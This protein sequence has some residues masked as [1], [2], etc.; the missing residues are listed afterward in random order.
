MSTVSRRAFVAGTAGVTAGVLAGLD[1]SAQ[2][3][4]KRGGTLV[5]ASA[6][7]PTLNP[8][9]LSGGGPG[10]PGAQLFA[11]LLEFDDQFR[12]RPYL[13]TSWD[14]SADGLAYTFHLVPTAVFHDGAP[15]TS[16]DVAF[17]LDT[18]RANSPFGPTMFGSVDRVETPDSHTAKFVMKRPDPAFLS[19]LAPILL[20]VL[21]KHVFDK[22]PIRMNPANLAPVGSGPF[23]F[24]EFKQ[25]NYVILER[26][27]NFFRPNRPLLDKIVIRIIHDSETLVLAL[28]SGEIDYVSGEGLHYSDIL[29]LQKNKKFVTT[30]K[31]FEA[32]GPVDY[33]QFNLR[34]PPFNK[35]LV[36]QAIAHAIDKNFI[37]DKLQYGLTKRLD[38]PLN[39][40]NPFASKDLTLYK[41]DLEKAKKLLNEAGYPMKGDARF[42]VTLDA[43]PFYP[44]GLVLVADYLKP[45]LKRIGIDVEQR[46][47]PDFG[48][49]VKW[50]SNYEYDF[51]MNSSWNY[52]DPTIGVSRLFLCNNQRK[53]VMWANNEG[54]CNP[55]VDHL[56]NT[57]AREMHMDVRKEL[58][59]SFQKNVTT[60]LPFIW[61]TTETLYAVFNKS[62]HNVQ[63]TVWG[64]L[65]PLDAAYK[66]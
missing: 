17:S 20:P 37:V 40:E 56:L 19:C 23:K 58:Y 64:P 44:D 62:V 6:G 57:A 49:W 2:A 4:P 46:T 53:G 9:I 12:P 45:Q 8:A 66:T 39:P 26:F 52:P 51:T 38:G 14:M 35:A 10:L 29:R 65:Q 59:R 28:E 5:I 25:G 33:L 61:T 50:I 32:L 55:V 3:E 21:P 15:I 63:N 48:T 34:K 16:E 36:R 31:G 1:R 24:V 60:D 30:R 47:S 13:A 18:V 41:Y 7:V 27:N 43:G 22:G 42:K 11:S 54:Y